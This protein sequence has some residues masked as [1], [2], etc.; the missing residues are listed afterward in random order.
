MLPTKKCFALKL[1]TENRNFL[2]L[3][4]KVGFFEKAPIYRRAKKAWG[5][6]YM[7]LSLDENLRSSV[8]PPI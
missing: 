8:P 4:T 5:Y 6:Q 2:S 3:P 7:K 1:P